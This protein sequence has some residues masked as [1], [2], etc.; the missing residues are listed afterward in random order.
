MSKENP[1]A[2]SDKK[3]SPVEKNAPATGQNQEVDLSPETRLRKGKV[4]ADLKKGFKVTVIDSADPSRC[5]VVEAKPGDLSVADDTKL[6]Q[7]EW[8]RSTA[9]AV[10]RYGDDL[11]FPEAEV[12]FAPAGP[13]DFRDDYSRSEL[14]VRRRKAVPGSGVKGAT[15][16]ERWENSASTNFEERE[17]YRIQAN[18]GGELSEVE[19]WR[20]YNSSSVDIEATR[21]FFDFIKQETIKH[22]P[23]S[24]IIFDWHEGQSQKPE[25]QL[26]EGEKQ[27]GQ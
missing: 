11:F 9:H 21:E 17:T 19:F 23:S 7:G 12:A 27:I 16:L 3:A 1:L 18:R 26:E 4:L 22:H 5:V 24:R 2:S 6:L 14:Q 20:R 15:T 25:S 10:T 13:M 8:I